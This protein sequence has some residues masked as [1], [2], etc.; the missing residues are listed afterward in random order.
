[1]TRRF[2]HVLGCLALAILIDV[3]FAAHNMSIASY[4]ALGTMGIIC[5]LWHV[6]VAIPLLDQ[7]TTSRFEKRLFFFGMKLLPMLA[8]FWMLRPEYQALA[9]MTVA[10]TLTSEYMLPLAQLLLLTATCVWATASIQS[11]LDDESVMVHR[12]LNFDVTSASAGVGSLVILVAAANHDISWLPLVG[13]AA[14]LA[15]VACSVHIG[16]SS[17]GQKTQYSQ[18]IAVSL[19]AI[20]CLMVIAYPLRAL[21]HQYEGDVDSLGLEDAGDFIL[22]GLFWAIAG[23]ACTACLVSNALYHPRQQS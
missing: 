7:D 14:A 13:L 19:K 5:T 15:W 1:M 23:A 16:A 6:K 2:P 12:N 9:A 21:M 20:A 17:A 8:S 22:S 10:E 18:L 3:A 11:C 4:F